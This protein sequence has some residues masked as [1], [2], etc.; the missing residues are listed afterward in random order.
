M[1]LINSIRKNKLVKAV[2]IITNFIVIVQPI[3]TSN[4]FANNGPLQPEF[5][6]PSVMSP[7]NY[8]DPFTGDFSYAID[9]L[10][11]VG[12]PMS[13]N[14]NA[15]VS[16]EQDASWVGLGWT[17]NPGSIV[18]NVR[19]LPDDFNGDVIAESTNIRPNIT[20]GVTTTLGPHELVGILLE[21][22]TEAEGPT[23]SLDINYNTYNGLGVSTAF[24]LLENNN[25][26]I[27]CSLSISS[28]TETSFGGVGITPQ[29]NL[30][31]KTKVIELENCIY[32][33]RNSVQSL[34]A[35]FTTNAGLKSFSVGSYYNSQ[36]YDDMANAVGKSRN[37]G[38]GVNFLP[39][40]D[41]NYT[42]SI[43][44]EFMS[45]SFMLHTVLGAEFL[46]ADYALKLEGYYTNSKLKEKQVSTPAY[47][48][49]HLRNES[50]VDT[51]V[52]YV[53][54]VN[55]EN[56]TSV[57]SNTPSLPIGYYTYDVYTV[58]APDISGNF[59]AYRNDWGYTENKFAKNSTVDVGI[60]GEFDAGGK[61]KIGVDVNASVGQSTS[62]T[63]SK[64]N[65]LTAEQFQ[66]KPLADEDFVNSKNQLFYFKYIG[67]EYSE[68]EGSFVT[69]MAET[70]P[71]EPELKNSFF[72]PK[73]ET[74][75][76]TYSDHN[77]YPGDGDG[78]DFSHEVSPNTYRNG[79]VTNPKSIEYFTKAEVERFEEIN[80]YQIGNKV[81]YQINDQAKPDHIIK[82]VITAEDGTKYIFGVPAY[83][84]EQQ[85]ILFNVGK[86][87]PKDAPPVKYEDDYLVGYTRE[88][89][90]IS[91]PQNSLENASGND[92]YYNNK[93]LPAYVYTYLLTDVISP[94]YIDITGDGPTD[95]DMGT[96]ITYTYGVK[97]GDIYK[98]DIESFSWRTPMV[99]AQQAAY[100][101]GMVNNSSDDKAN[102]IYGRKEVWFLHSVETKTGKADFF[103]SL[104][105]DGY[106]AYGVDGFI[107][108]SGNCLKKLDS[109]QV[110]S[111]FDYLR[112][113]YDGEEGELGIMDGFALTPVKTV[114]FNYDY[115]L[116]PNIPNNKSIGASDGG[117]GRLTLT[118]VYYKY[119]NSNR[120]KYDY[121]K[122]TYNEGNEE[123]QYSRSWNDRWGTIQKDENLRPNRIFPYTHQEER[124][125]ADYYA[126]L[127][128]L[129]RIDIPGGGYMEI[130]YEA[131]DYA[132][133][134][135][136][137]AGEMFRLKSCFSQISSDWDSDYE[138][139]D[140]NDFIQFDTDEPGLL[141]TEPIDDGFPSQS[142]IAYYLTFELLDPIPDDGF[143][144]QQAANNLFIEQYLLEYN[145]KRHSIGGVEDNLFFRC[146]INTDDLYGYYSG[147]EENEYVE[148]YGS[149][150][151]EEDSETGLT[152]CGVAKIT[153][154]DATDPYTIGYIKLNPVAYSGT[155]DDIVENFLSGLGIDYTSDFTNYHINPIVKATWQYCMLNA[156]N[157]ILNVPPPD[158]ALEP[159][160]FVKQL[161]DKILVTEVLNM[162]L[163][164]NAKMAHSGFGSTFIPD[165]S[166]VRLYNPNGEKIGGGLR[167]KEIR[168]GDGWAVMTDNNE[169]A[170]VYGMA[171]SYIDP[172]TKM[173]S[174]VASWEPAAGGEENSMHYPDTYSHRDGEYGYELYNEHPYGESFFPAASV[175]YAYVQEQPF[176]QYEINQGTG[177]LSEKRSELGKTIYKFFTAKEFPTIVNNT[178]VNPINK[179]LATPFFAP[180]ISA[181]HKLYAASQGFVIESN[182]M[183]GKPI[184][185]ELLN[186]NGSET[187][188]KTEYDYFKDES[189]KLLN[190]LPCLNSIGEIEMKS[191]GITYDL[192]NDYRITNT[193]NIG[194]GGQ[195]GLDVSGTGP[196][197]I[198]IPN[199]Y[200]H[201]YAANSTSAFAVIT[202][203]V[204]R[205]GIIKSVTTKT[206]GSVVVSSNLVFDAKTGNPLIVTQQ[207]EFGDTYYVSNIPAHWI[208]EGMSYASD[209]W[210]YKFTCNGKVNYSTSEI[211]D[212][213]LISRLQPGDYVAFDVD[214]LGDPVSKGGWL[215][216][217]VSD[218]GV[219]KYYIID[220]LGNPINFYD[221]PESIVD[222]TAFVYDSGKQNTA[223]VSV[224]TIISK[225]DPIDWDNEE[226]T[227]GSL[228]LNESIQII[229]ATSSEFT[230]VWR[231][232]CSEPATLDEVCSCAD[233][234]TAG[235][236]HLN[237]LLASLIHSNKLWS[238]YKDDEYYYENV[239]L[240]KY[241]SEYDETYYGY[242]FDDNLMALLEFQAVDDPYSPTHHVIWFSERNDADHSLLDCTIA[243]NTDE[244]QR[245]NF[246]L[247]FGD[248]EVGSEA[249]NEIFIDPASISV[250]VSVPESD[251]ESCSDVYSF[252]LTFTYT[253]EEGEIVSVDAECNE[254]LCFPLRHCETISVFPPY[255]YGGPGDN[256]NPYLR[257][258]KGIWR[259]QVAYKF[260]TERTPEAYFTTET[261]TGNVASVRN[262]GEYQLFEPFWTYDT[263]TTNWEKS[264]SDQ[265]QWATKNTNF[266]PFALGAETVDVLGIY[267]SQTYGLNATTAEMVSGNA[268]YWQI[269]FDN[270]EDDLYYDFYRG[271][272]C[273]QRH[274]NIEPDETGEVT[275][276]YAHSGNFSMKIPASGECTY[277]HLLNDISNEERTVYDK[278]FEISNDD[279][280][281]EFAPNFT[282]TD[283]VYLLTFWYKD[284]DV[285]PQ[286]LDDIDLAI[287]I[288][289]DLVNLITGD[290]VISDE[291]EGWRRVEVKFTMPTTMDATDIF[292]ITI[293]NENSEAAAYIDDVKVN[294]MQS[295]NNCYVYDFISHRVM[296][297]LD[298][299]H[300]ATYYEYDANGSLVRIK[301]ET[302]RGIFTIQ[303]SRYNTSKKDF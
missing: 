249:Y 155:A 76:L 156:K 206:N 110:F 292:K 25:N 182:N 218:V 49:L 284:A 83:N 241:D 162:F 80:K 221:D 54:D 302:E 4:A 32:K 119:Y 281:P 42:P 278:P 228:V 200:P 38:F 259:P 293:S 210:R 31:R 251:E 170:S 299:N 3:L 69:N 193:K 258:L 191:I 144:S 140:E 268:G 136:R 180:F 303:D 177:V 23:V 183:H 253:N 94:D 266:D 153:G 125:E 243:R 166:I 188:T 58:T 126:G 73:I 96:Y 71:V 137:R 113:K 48:Y 74:E 286:H 117:T 60:G 283:E 19:G 173:S 116:C 289:S 102:I 160:D 296:A 120:A 265:W 161:G 175:G 28:N 171:Y 12:I 61:I 157:N 236:S 195:F 244:A 276:L 301:K 27:D 147:D 2:M 5:Q 230:D 62:K 275:R 142:E 43:E 138:F 196:L 246:T 86:T 261:P 50:N 237:N 29:L 56:E 152:N 18:R 297:E 158:E 260:L 112:D 279:C 201:I 85:E 178:E 150:D 130:D 227:E 114:V 235:A 13:L 10:S 187:L 9:L 181:S 154:S 257:G 33:I 280:I 143:M 84:I 111:K 168:Y 109:I 14:Y 134:Q 203:H 82:I 176:G 103:M 15:G 40:F 220:H 107:N 217:S 198:P 263:E 186:A 232:F 290:A 184:S 229:D 219:K 37:F 105:E 197:I 88:D 30:F 255:C 149:L 267:S 11:D 189:G 174:G 52:N 205:S 98:P 81:K 75:N 294:P 262:Q 127:W 44:K 45:S 128:S 21:G 92:F 139:V 179:R 39:N 35:T 106:T 234:Y 216:E 93:S 300:Y 8:V 239:F 145:M 159:S 55:R 209:N 287:S 165:Q 245:C 163:N 122:F 95:D 90:V 148:G 213:E 192:F 226:H 164:P 208:Y 7:G 194:G 254:F 285:N 185:I 204:V 250:S 233:G 272:T 240:L 167:V 99:D 214:V 199:A 215:Y 146:Y 16:M 70:L 190:T 72:T 131:D 78:P 64:N 169:G 223:A 274:F 222:V 100:V 87:N 89:G 67:E 57:Q 212:L 22:D 123:E 133:V 231:M 24:N 65:K 242:S 36:K 66:H 295:A 101:E 6:G 225:Q 68:T 132:Y 291:I 34:S 135:N 97:D 248:I 77:Y 121:Y 20:A 26:A 17:L 298:D 51:K 63:F 108:F 288:T 151:L 141:F 247:D 41:N 104:R 59:R 264:E 224:T 211:T 202:K 118:A 53:E 238:E 277:T 91:N 1:N 273:H 115:K 270:F 252:T 207:N 46:F 172:I 256:V 269:G 282:D 47:G 271:A 129:S 124:T 79:F